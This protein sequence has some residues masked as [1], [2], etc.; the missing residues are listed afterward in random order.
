MKHGSNATSA[1]LC[2]LVF[3]GADFPLHPCKLPTVDRGRSEPAIRR[4]W[5][6]PYLTRN[7]L[8][9]S[10]EHKANGQALQTKLGET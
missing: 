7:G 8:V 5:N 6:R 3:S 9:I 1:Q 4:H 10:P 2:R